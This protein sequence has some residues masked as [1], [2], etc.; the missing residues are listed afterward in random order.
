MKM[1]SHAHITVAPEHA[2]AIHELLG[3]K[4]SEYEEKLQKVADPL[5]GEE[6]KDLANPAISTLKHH[7][8]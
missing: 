2:K 8:R 6:R 3:K 4:L 7:Y 5:E 1:L